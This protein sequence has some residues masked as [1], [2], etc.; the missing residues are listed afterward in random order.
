MREN[1]L[2]L[3]TR[4]NFV[5]Y[6]KVRGWVVKVTIGNRYQKAFPDLYCTHSRF[7]IRWIE[8]K[9]KERKGKLFTPAQEKEFP[10]LW[11]NGTPIWVLKDGGESDYKA[12]FDHP[13]LKDYMKVKGEYEVN[14]KFNWELKWDKV[15]TQL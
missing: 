4:D 1:I 2:E 10:I 8:M 7:G 5:S 9:R 14:Q 13:N 11:Q 3:T 6:L 15:S 12:L